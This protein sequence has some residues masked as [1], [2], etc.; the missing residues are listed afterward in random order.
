LTRPQ[1]TTLPFVGTATKR[2]A[3]QQVNYITT[4]KRCNRLEAA[5]RHLGSAVDTGA[6]GRQW[7]PGAARHADPGPLPFD[8]PAAAHA[9]RDGKGGGNGPPFNG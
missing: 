5:C 1:A 6:F 4:C 7:P 2:S 3:P 9:G 8:G